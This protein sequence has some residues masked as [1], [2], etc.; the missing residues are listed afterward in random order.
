MTEQTQEKETNL[1]LELR[2]IAALL[3][4]INVATQRGAIRAEEMVEVGTVYN[5]VNAFLQASLPP[6]PAE[7]EAEETPEE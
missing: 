2:D 1:S 5:K 6:Q 7:G 3:Q 4:I